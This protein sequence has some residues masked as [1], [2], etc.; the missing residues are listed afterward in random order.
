MSGDVPK[1]SGT[2]GSDLVAQ[3]WP[4]W[5][6][7]NYVDGSKVELGRSEVAGRG[8]Q[9]G[10]DAA[11]AVP[12]AGGS[13]I[14]ADALSGK[15]TT[16]GAELTAKQAHHM[17]AAEGMALNASNHFATKTILTGIAEDHDAAKD[18]LI[19]AGM[20]LGIP[21]AK[22][23]E[24]LDELKR[25]TSTAAENVGQANQE[26]HQTLT[27]AI[28]GGSALKAP[29]AGMP[30]G[31]GL[32][33]DVPSQLQP[34]LQMGTQG[35]QMASG[36][37]GQLV[38]G[39][40]GLSG[41]FTDPLNQLMSAVG[42]GAQ[43]G[44]GMDGIADPVSGGA[45]GEHGSDTRE[46]SHRGNDNTDR[47]DTD[48]KRRDGEPKTLGA[49][50]HDKSQAP[51]THL[52]S[53]GSTVQIDAG[54]A[55]THLSSGASI[56]DAPVT[57]TQSAAGVGAGVAQQQPMGG[58]LGGAMGGLGLAHAGSPAAQ[59]SSKGTD[60]PKTDQDRDAEAAAVTEAAT[61]S[62]VVIDAAGVM[63]PSN[64]AEVMFGTRIL[65]HMVHQD[66][67]LTAAAVAVYP[68]GSHTLATVCSPLALGVMPGYVT[69]P[70]GAMALASLKGLPGDFRAHW[71]GIG[72]PV[73][74]LYVAIEQGYLACPE[75]IVALRTPDA[76]VATLPD[77]A[78]V[79]QVTRETLL[80]T[81]PVDDAAE[82][83]EQR[84]DPDHVAGVIES[85]AD[86]W[87]VPADLD[88]PAAFNEMHNRIWYQNRNPEYVFAMAWWMLI[89]AKSALAGGDITRAAALSWQLLALPPAPTL[90]SAAV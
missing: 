84:V 18:A 24:A 60:R 20:S 48:D 10:T 13:G 57:T 46:V 12:A 19:A 4:Q 66:P 30:G 21:Q 72:D 53:S 2:E 70:H 58:Q 9:T 79:V 35:P 33:A 56:A 17:A 1:P 38:S 69:T 39:L 82:A 89:E 22:M 88:L 65:A 78:P 75:V 63:N 67:S 59:A 41:A 81:D 34:L 11:A 47:Q 90:M 62:A 49:S 37:V 73:W 44:G 74:P 77:D 71:A 52:A 86:E 31:A 64:R 14:A 27:S 29:P 45:G 83:H 15:Y 76:P 6:E 25:A 80:T 40:S 51:A 28:N 85:M 87:A 3:H 8:A 26:T 5:S 16:L 50:S 23:Q 55:S 61:V 36:A 32:P 43:A 54:A 7:T 68:M 42:Q